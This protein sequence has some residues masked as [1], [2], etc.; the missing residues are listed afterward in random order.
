MGV[1]D[2]TVVNNWD[3]E[4]A[5]VA[6]ELDVKRILELGAEINVELGRE[7]DA[8]LVLGMEVD[9]ALDIG[10]SHEVT[11]V[12]VPIFSENVV[13]GD[14][15]LDEPA[16]LEEIIVPTELEVKAVEVLTELVTEATLEVTI[17]LVA[18]KEGPTELVAVIDGPTEL[19][20][21]LKILTEVELL[22][23]DTV[24][25]VVAI[26]EEEVTGRILELRVGVKVITALLL[27]LLLTLL[28]LATLLVIVLLP[29]RSM[30]T[31]TQLQKRSDLVSRDH[32][33]K[34]SP[35]L[36]RSTS[37]GI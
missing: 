36:Q 1:G 2:E 8:A 6:S 23:L 4:G 24:L 13:V 12:S 10:V 21:M 5:G 34:Q 31:S 17:E 3:I 33:M 37:A 18:V 16:E 27:K 25:E 28:L 35:S 15:V 22:E 14:S 32:W 26:F 19:D 7:V 9:A 30:T 29:G 20:E 11:T